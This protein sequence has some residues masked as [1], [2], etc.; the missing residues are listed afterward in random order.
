[1]GWFDTVLSIG[2]T[3]GRVAGALSGVPTQ[4]C[5]SFGPTGD[6]NPQFGSVGFFVDANGNTQAFNNSMTASVGLSFPGDPLLGVGSTDIILAPTQ[7]IEMDPAFNSAA[8]AGFDNFQ[9]MPTLSL[10]ADS[11]NV[12]GSGG[13]NIHSSTTQ[14]ATTGLAVKVGP[15]LS[16][17]LNTSNRT[18]QIAVVGTLALTG[19]VLLNIRGAGDTAVK[20]INAVRKPSDA[21]S[22]NPQ[23]ITVDIPVGLNIDNGLTFIEIDAAVEGALSNFVP[24][25]YP[26]KSVQLT[27]ADHALIAAMTAVK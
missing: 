1:M 24:D 12:G 10:T 20:I 15:Y 5:I 16:A 26:A 21:N 22:D 9:I 3:I 7:K 13:S 14:T 25:H 11:N 6:I 18:L 8:A 23:T 4:K 17:T 19:I 27:K 2:T